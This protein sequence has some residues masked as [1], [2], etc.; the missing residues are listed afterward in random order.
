MP[1]VPL[2]V[3]PALEVRVAVEGRVDPLRHQQ[4]RLALN[5]VL[6]LTAGL[7]GSQR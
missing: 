3:E 4:V 2:L 7:V 5:H 6:E 1:S